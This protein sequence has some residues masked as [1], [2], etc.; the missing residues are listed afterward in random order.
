MR[1][2]RIDDAAP[3]ARLHARHGGADGMKR[4]RQID[5]DDLVP[6]LD[7]EFL[8]RRDVLNAGIVDEDVER[9]E[10]LLGRVDHVG[11]FGGLG[12]VGRRIGRLHAEILFDAG[13]LFF[14]RGGIAEAIDGDVGALPRRERAHRPSPMPD[15]EPVTS[16]FFP[17]SMII[18]KFKALRLR[19]EARVTHCSSCAKRRQCETLCAAA[20]Y[21]KSEVP[22]LW[23]YRENRYKIVTMAKLPAAWCGPLMAQDM[24]RASGLSGARPRS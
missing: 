15:V 13:A 18:P 1:G 24:T 9:A 23:C 16:A 17:F 3:F 8:D 21:L 14:D 11:N 19:R 20:Q 22:A 2:R 5:R 4:R 12:H 10:S 7:R 6:F